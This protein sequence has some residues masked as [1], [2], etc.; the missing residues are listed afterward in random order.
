MCVCHLFINKERSYLRTLLPT[1]KLLP[2]QTAQ[3]ELKT[4]KRT[5]SVKIYVKLFLKTFMGL[6]YDLRFLRRSS[7]EVRFGRASR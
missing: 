5:I 1:V 2:P 7:D 6:D 3:A 4:I